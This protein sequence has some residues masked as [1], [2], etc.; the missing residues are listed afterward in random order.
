MK[1]LS[2]IGVDEVVVLRHLD[3]DGQEIDRREIHNL[4]VSAG[5][6][7]LAKFIGD[8]IPPANIT[9]M[10]IGTGTTAPAA[11]NVA[12]ETPFGSRVA[13]TRSYV[14]SPSPRVMVTASFT[15]VTGAV[16]E[17]GLF[18]A[19]SDGT[20]QARSTF[21]AL[22]LTADDKLDVTHYIVPGV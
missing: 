2:N 6:E 12:L 4:V 20:M 5:L 8:T 19:A 17:E 11:G 18:N 13:A 15:G 10:G 16:T 1:R 14:A 3:K 22:N 21:G 9:H 7:W